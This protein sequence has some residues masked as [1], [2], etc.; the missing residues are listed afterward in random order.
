[1]SSTAPQVPTQEALWPEELVVSGP[2][3]AD[4]QALAEVTF[5]VFDLETT[6][7]APADGGITE[8][9][10]VKVR[11]GEQLGEFQTLVRPESPIPAFISMLT[12]ITDSMVSGAPSLGAVLPSFLE[13]CAGS[14]LVAHNAPYDVGFLKAACERLEHEWPGNTVIDTVRLARQIISNDEAPNRKLHTLAALFGSPIEPDHRALHDARATVHVLHALLGRIGTLGVTTL[15][16]LRGFSA[17]VPESTR[18]KRHLADGLPT[19]PGV[20]LFRDEKD[21]VLYV[22]TSVNIRTR[23]RNYFTAAEQRTRMREMVARAARVTPVPC[24]TTLE[25]RV[26]EIRLIAEHAPPYNRRSKTP[27]RKPWVKLTSEAYPRLSVVRE[28]QADGATYTGPFPSQEQAELAVAALHE[29]YPLRRCTPRLPKRPARNATACML[30]D[31][32]RCGAPCVG[33]IDP[34]GYAEVAEQVRVAML[35]DSGQV[36]EAALRRAGSLSEVQRYE[37]AAQHRDRL[38]SY[39]RGAARS[40]RLTPIAAVPHLVGARPAERGGWEF[41][42]VRHGRLAGTTVSPPGADPMPYV[43]ALNLTGEVV[44]PRE[45]PYPSAHPEETEIVLNWL[46]QPGTRLVEL[47]GTWAWPVRGAAQARFGLPQDVHATVPPAP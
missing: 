36:V 16:E 4:A 6:G 7:G 37:E 17:K 8:I 29:A 39:L 2:A 11:G 9:G 3:R 38:L 40:Q 45:V 5:V 12:G 18:R 26:R 46:E 28:V 32:G 35:S 20:Y 14:V 25:A 30:A 33:G 13:F 31:I 1:M 21:Q 42:L 27:E 44:T 34:Q 41:A 47:E 10:A 24:A 23:V 43:N 19:G 22:G 15:G